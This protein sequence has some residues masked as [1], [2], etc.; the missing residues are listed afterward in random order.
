MCLLLDTVDVVILKSCEYEYIEAVC[1]IVK[2][3]QQE[4]VAGSTEGHL[5]RVRRSKYDT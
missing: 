1:F 3:I 5:V 2:L 4:A